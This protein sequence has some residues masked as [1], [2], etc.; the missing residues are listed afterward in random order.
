MLEKFLTDVGLSEKESHVYLTLLRGGKLNVADIATHANVKRTTVYPVI[1]SL[2]EKKLVEEITDDGKTFFTAE[3]PERLKTFFQA[4]K[5]AFEE[6]EKLFDEFLP[7]IRGLQSMTGVQP[8]YKYYEGREGL[9]ESIKDLL[10]TESDDKVMYMTYSQDFVEKMFTPQEAKLAQ[11]LRIK[12]D[13]SVKSIYSWSKGDKSESEKS[14]RVRI[15]DSQNYPI[16]CDITIF[17]DKVRVY[18]G[19]EKIFAL[20]IK[21]KEIAETIKTLHKLSYEHLKVEK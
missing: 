5:I 15:I 2:K 10:E 17:G 9:L 19:G 21:S 14:Q 1:E 8:V 3:A 11:S 6:Q 18:S 7:Q 12:N 20:I 4:R 13:I 16:N